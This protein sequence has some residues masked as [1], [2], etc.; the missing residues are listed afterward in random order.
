MK[1]VFLNGVATPQ[2]SVES[3]KIQKLAIALGYAWG[4]AGSKVIGLADNQS[5]KFKE[6]G[7]MTPVSDFDG[8]VTVTVDVLQSALVEARKGQTVTTRAALLQIFNRTKCREI[9]DAIRSLLQANFEKGDTE[10]FVV[11]Q[12]LLDEAAAKL[13]DEQRAYF[14]D[15]GLVVTY[16]NDKYTVTGA[17]GT[18]VP[19][20]LRSVTVQEVGVSPKLGTILMD[21]DGN[22]YFA[23]VK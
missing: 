9:E 2:S 1:N 23:T 3:V 14:K 7:R 6:D 15:A 4:K 17:V 21:S 13:N 12:E 19:A 22:V 18:D 11:P 20:N 10:E 8:D 16:V 5:I